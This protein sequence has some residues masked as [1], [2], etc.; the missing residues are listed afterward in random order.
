MDEEIL[1]DLVWAL[2]EE[3]PE[4][5]DHFMNPERDGSTNGH[6]LR[7]HVLFCYQKIA[8][9]E[10]E[11]V[12]SNKEGVA[13]AKVE[14]YVE[15]IEIALFFADAIGMTET[16]TLDFMIRVAS[17]QSRSGKEQ[18]YYTIQLYNEALGDLYFSIEPDDGA[19]ATDNCSKTQK[20]VSFTFKGSG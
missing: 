9:A 5:V 15:E 11:R 14:M 1:D 4:A 8:S 12:D 18:Q 20:I 6:E 17:E 13:R 3:G 2:I 7:E 19:T 10:S 16:E